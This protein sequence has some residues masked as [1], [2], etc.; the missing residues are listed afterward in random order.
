MFCS[1]EL[2]YLL[3]QQAVK[4][5]NRSPL[6]ALLP[7]DESILHC[8]SQECSPL[9]VLQ[10]R[11]LSPTVILMDGAGPFYLTPLVLF[12]AST[13]H[14]VPWACKQRD[15]QR[16][17]KQINVVKENMLCFTVLRSPFFTIQPKFSVFQPVVFLQVN[18]KPF[19][20]YM[21]EKFTYSNSNNGFYLNTPV[22]F[23][24]LTR[25][26]G[27]HYIHGLYSVLPRSGVQIW[28]LVKLLLK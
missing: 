16:N 14:S 1:S 4:F 6:L 9:L 26:A 12:D 2:I 28:F 5:A 10:P 21:S 25:S 7:W 22:Y 27:R 13:L 23:F 11:S 24:T 3:F 15:L 19:L 17:M 20:I 18:I 8:H